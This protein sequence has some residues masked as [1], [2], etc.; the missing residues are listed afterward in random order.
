MR[1]TLARAAASAQSGFTLLEILV[2]MVI[3][4]VLVA[5]LTIAVGGNG[6]RQLANSAE[7]F[8]ALLGHACNEAELSGREIGAVVGT[9]GYAFRRLDGDT[10][11]AFA[12]A[13]E[14]RA[15]EWPPGLRIEF[16]REGRPLELATP[17]HE[18]PQL[19]C[20]SSGEL[21]PFSLVLALGDAAARYRVAGGEDGTL[22]S[23]R[24]RTPQ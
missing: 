21:T 1:W 10:W 15:R 7:R 18:T 5:A 9:Q 3:S 24:I 8:E 22:T 4:A 6:E 2:V 20:F 12:K 16:M 17:G 13:D 23:T 19:V 11:R 14:L